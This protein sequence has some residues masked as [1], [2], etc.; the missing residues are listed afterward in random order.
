MDHF[1][2]SILSYIFFYIQMNFI[3]VYVID[4]IDEC[5]MLKWLFNT[6]LE[7]INLYIMCLFSLLKYRVMSGDN[8]QEAAAE[9]AF[10]L[11]SSRQR[12][13][14]LAFAPDSPATPHQ[15]SQS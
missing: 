7:G 4:Y 12:G 2:F 10:I 6:M 3:L 13:L 1:I 14:H 5:I 8:A 9:L 11:Q 15:D